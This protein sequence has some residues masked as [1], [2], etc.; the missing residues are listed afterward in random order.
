MKKKV[1]SVLERWILVIAGL[2]AI[3][4]TIKSII[5]FSKDVIPSNFSDYLFTLISLMAFATLVY[6]ISRRSPVRYDFIPNLDD[7]EY[8]AK[9]IQA[10]KHIR[11]RGLRFREALKNGNF[12]N[13]LKYAKEVQLLIMAKFPHPKNSLEEEHNKKYK[14]IIEI[15]NNLKK[16]GVNLVVREVQGCPDYN[17]L[18]FDCNIIRRKKY[19]PHL[20]S[21]KNS[22]VEIYH[23]ERAKNHIKNIIKKF[24]DDWEKATYV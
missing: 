23:W 1:Y 8:Q 3:F 5:L 14:E 19:D 24:D 20:L 4:G 2:I 18:I 12:I 17:E 9:L 7:I 16:Q 10:S 6:F 11:F 15:I 21:A 22:E 13:S